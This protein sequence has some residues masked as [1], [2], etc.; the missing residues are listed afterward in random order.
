VSVSDLPDGLGRFSAA[1]LEFLVDDGYSLVRLEE[2][3]ALDEQSLGARL[4]PPEGAPLDSWLLARLKR[5]AGGTLALSEDVVEICDGAVYVIDFVVRSGGK[6][7]GKVQLQAGPE[8]AALL[9]VVSAD[10]SLVIERFT[11]ALMTAPEDV[12]ACRVRVRDPRWREDESVEY[13]H[14][15]TSYL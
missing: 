12:A 8:G 5:L 7:I 2:G 14:D 9:G 15:G 11:A 13:G 3:T 6:P 10:P 4:T 1:E